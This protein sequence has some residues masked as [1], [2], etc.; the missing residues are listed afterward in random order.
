MSIPLRYGTTYK[1][2][3]EKAEQEKVSIPLR[4]GTT[5]KNVNK[6][7]FKSINVSIPLRYGTTI[8]KPEDALNL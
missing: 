1:E 7:K 4:Y 6:Y 3:V 2:Q 5:Q 8:S